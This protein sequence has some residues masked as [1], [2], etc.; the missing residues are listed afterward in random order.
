MQLQ[1]STKIIGSASARMTHSINV[2]RNQMST[3]SRLV[4]LL[5]C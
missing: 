5:E 2:Y 4:S 1:R 3:A